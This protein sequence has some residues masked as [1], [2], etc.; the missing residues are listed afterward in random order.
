MTPPKIAFFGH[1]DKMRQNR[2]CPFCPGSKSKCI[3]GTRHNDKTPRGYVQCP[4][5]GVPW[6]KKPPKGYF[7]PGSPPPPAI[8]FV[9]EKAKSILSVKTRKENDR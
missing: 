6:A 5:G 7:D 9:Q 3:F 4:A 1:K 2:I 8:D